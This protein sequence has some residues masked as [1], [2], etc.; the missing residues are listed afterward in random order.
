MKP[1]L[2]ERRQRLYDK[3]AQENIAL[4]MFED[5]EGRRD[6]AIRWLTGHPADALLFLSVERK[7]LLIPWDSN[8]AVFY[9]EADTVIPYSQFERQPV[10]ALRE[11]AAFMKTP[12]G[13]RLEIPP[14][15]SYTTFLKYVEEL[16]DFD[17]LCRNDGLHG[18]TK[19][20]RLIKDDEEI[21]IYR[22][23]AKITNE[24]IDLLEKMVC[25]GKLKTETDAAL[26]IE[27]ECRK[28]GCEGT[29]FETLAAGPERSF[30]IHAFP[31]YTGAEFATQGLSILDFGLKYKGY[32]TDVTMTFARSPLNK[33]QE[34]LLN[35]TEK[36]YKL[37]FSM[38]R[39]GAS[40]MEIAGAVDSFFGKSKKAMPHSLG[41]GIGLETHEA[42]FLRDRPD[43]DRLLSAGM[44]FTLE[45]GLYD[46]VHGGCRLENDILITTE[47]VE[48]LT[49]SR[50]VRL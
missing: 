36:A 38:V 44:V 5:A 23:A 18:A 10:K 37:A 11:A 14:I 50:I 33:S 8:M 48:A 43:N 49:N 24:I 41:H 16:N 17:V 20:L 40:T 19:E 39:A 32:T 46:P 2:E 45:P 34:K 13:S 9:A 4:L 35:L 1:F 26:F 15:T 30:G 47:G 42:P 28:R 22:K 7:S 12:F 31:A 3:M 27:A 25:S 6:P 21:G 29:G